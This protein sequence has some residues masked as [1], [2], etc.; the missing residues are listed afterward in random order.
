MSNSHTMIK[1][2][3]MRRVRFIWFTRR[4]LPALILEVVGGVLFIQKIAEY[5]FVNNVL[6]NAVTHTFTRSPVMF[7]DFF[8]RALINTE[9]MVQVLL[10]AS[11]LAAFL[12]AKDIRRSLRAAPISVPSNFSGFSRVT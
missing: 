1:Q 5:V 10:L 11:A 9:I 8:F 4:V 6:Q 3:I 12:F 2:N 7:A